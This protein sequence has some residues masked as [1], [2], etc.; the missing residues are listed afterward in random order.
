[1]RFVCIG[2][3]FI[4]IS[5]LSAQDRSNVAYEAFMQNRPG[6]AIPLLYEQAQTDGA[7]HQY[8]DLGIAA[9]HNDEF[10]KAVVWLLQ[11]HQLAPEQAAPRQ[12]L[13]ALQVELPSS[14]L[15][16]LGP[17]VI[18]GTGYIGLLCMGLA[19]LSLAAAICL[20]QKRW[21]Y[22]LT[23]ASFLALSLPGAIAHS[24][25]QQR[26]LLANATDCPLLGPTGQPLQ[27]LPAGTVFI[28]EKTMPNNRIL[29]R[30]ANHERGFIDS[31]YCYAAP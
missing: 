29:I 26:D 13:Q 20:S 16:Q 6:E 25:D 7:W 14:W 31:N 27:T 21:L 19:G 17:L 30:L 18:P 28:A 11:A 24:V 23:G 4:T 22:L 8:F 15:D 9:Y 12:A 2:L 3:L 1:M 10:G 5:L